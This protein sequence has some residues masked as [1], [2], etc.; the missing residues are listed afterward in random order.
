MV[1]EL[2]NDIL[3][4]YGYVL[5]IVIKFALNAFDYLILTCKV[6]RSA[7]IPEI[8]ENLKFFNIVSIVII[9]DVGILI[10]PI[11]YRQIL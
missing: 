5:L 6:N 8:L 10:S 3:K 1:T 9:E 7:K 11:G 4:M 2:V